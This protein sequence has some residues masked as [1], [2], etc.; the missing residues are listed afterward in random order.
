MVKS[1]N[2]TGR[3]KLHGI[4]EKLIFRYNDLLKLSGVRAKTTKASNRYLDGDDFDLARRLN[5]HKR[6]KL[7]SAVR[8]LRRLERHHRQ[9]LRITKW[10]HDFQRNVP[11]DHIGIVF[12]FKA[13][14]KLDQG[15]EAD[16]MRNRKQATCFGL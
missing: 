16:D 1:K 8:Q 4:R 7:K 3:C 5:Q 13:K 2:Q 15:D 14:I 11:E 6:K 9:H 10:W 12:D